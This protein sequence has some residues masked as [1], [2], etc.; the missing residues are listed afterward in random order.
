ML[1]T[2]AQFLKL[3]NGGATAMTFTQQ[4]SKAF[5]IGG[6]FLVAAIFGKRPGFTYV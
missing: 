5:G 6:F 1:A 2:F 4:I 3:L